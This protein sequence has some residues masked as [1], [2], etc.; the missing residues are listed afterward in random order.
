MQGISSDLFSLKKNPSSMSTTDFSHVSDSG[1][2]FNLT[3]LT[4]RD[5]LEN[6][7]DMKPIVYFL[8]KFSFI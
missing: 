5:V 2:V 4:D 6:F 3:R 1:T 7:Q 8:I